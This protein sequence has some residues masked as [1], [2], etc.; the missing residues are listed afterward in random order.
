MNEVIA[1]LFAV[2]PHQKCHQKNNGRLG[3]PYTY[4]YTYIGYWEFRGGREGG[5]RVVLFNI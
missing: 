3:I 4:M 5:E 2:R 1:C